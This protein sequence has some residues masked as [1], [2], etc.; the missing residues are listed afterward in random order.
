[1][2]TKNYKS[3]LSD[4]EW[5]L[6]SP[7]IPKPKTTGRRAAISRR[8]LVDAMFYVTKT[9]C[10]WE[11]L[12]H[13]FPNWKTVYHYFRVWRLEGVWE[14]I[15]TALRQALRRSLGRDVQPSAAIID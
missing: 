15:H 11:W 7:L 3:D 10:G 4:T 5:A 2:Q 6:V 1:M 14:A 9:G 13:D 12:P 8:R